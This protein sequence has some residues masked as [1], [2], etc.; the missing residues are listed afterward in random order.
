MTKL[1]FCVAS[2]LGFSTTTAAAATISLDAP[3]VS[4]PVEVGN[5]VESGKV[6]LIG[7]NGDV[8]EYVLPGNPQGRV[9]LATSALADG[10][11]Q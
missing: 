10:A 11:Y 4:I 8:H 2:A 3:G 5:G 1:A 7:P 6:T 9:A